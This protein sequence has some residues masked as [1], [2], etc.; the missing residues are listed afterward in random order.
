MNRRRRW[1]QGCSVSSRRPAEA[2]QQTQYT[3]DW[4]NGP[5]KGVCVSIFPHR[6]RSEAPV[7]WITSPRVKQDVYWVS[8]K[9]EC[10]STLYFHR[11]EHPPEGLDNVFSPVWY[12]VSPVSSLNSHVSLTVTLDGDKPKRGKWKEKNPT[13]L[14][15]SEAGSVRLIKSPKKEELE[16]WKPLSLCSYNFSAWGFPGIFYKKS[17]TLF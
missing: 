3:W 6:V 4:F 5:S 16:G 10:S 8:S 15:H 13:R 9:S 17:L 12:S 1:C 11:L 7:I 14:H 2:V